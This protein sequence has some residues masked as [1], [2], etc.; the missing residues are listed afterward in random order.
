[1]CM[2]VRTIHCDALSSE[3]VCKEMI[4]H[5]VLMQPVSYEDNCFNVKSLTCRVVVRLLCKYVYTKDTYR[6]GALLRRN[7]RR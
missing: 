7:P 6:E 2:V 4:A 3:L 1:M 5:D